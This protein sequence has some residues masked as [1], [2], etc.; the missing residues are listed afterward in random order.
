MAITPR[1]AA[2]A[3][4]PTVTPKPSVVNTPQ[5]PGRNVLSTSAVLNLGSAEPPKNFA[6]L[7]ANQIANSPSQLKV[8]LIL[9]QE[10]LPITRGGILSTHVVS[11]HL[12]DITFV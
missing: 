3:A 6:K 2:M 1:T 4:N 11:V 9:S 7:A 5:N 12:T 8:L 10:S